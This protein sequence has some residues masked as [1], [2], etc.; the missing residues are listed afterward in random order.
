[1]DAG[2]VSDSIHEIGDHV[3]VGVVLLDELLVV[4]GV[5][6]LQVLVE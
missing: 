2:E 6:Y 3:L 5:L 1:M 4:F